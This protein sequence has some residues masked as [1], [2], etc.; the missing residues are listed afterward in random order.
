MQPGITAASKDQG[1]RAN[2]ES[3][4]IGGD[5]MERKDVPYLL[6]IGMNIEI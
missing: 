5:D 4:I 2:Q 6:K 3:R 1:P